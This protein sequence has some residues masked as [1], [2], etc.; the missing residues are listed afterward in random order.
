MAT[1]HT[2]HDLPGL[3]GRYDFHI[4]N[5][6]VWIAGH[7]GGRDGPTDA[8]HPEQEQWMRQHS[9]LK[10]VYYLTWELP[11][12]ARSTFLALIGATPEPLK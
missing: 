4:E 9:G 3:P 12:D 6:Y 5:N 1:L 8:D 7:G 10:E 2:T 11:E